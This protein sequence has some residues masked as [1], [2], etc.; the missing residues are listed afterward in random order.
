M[1]NLLSAKSREYKAAEVRTELRRHRDAELVLDAIAPWRAFSAAVVRASK[2]VA[3]AVATAAAA[4]A[5]AAAASS[6]CTGAS[7]VKTPTVRAPT[8]TLLTAAATTATG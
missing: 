1:P 5:A 4:A 7:A 8:L 2:A 3:T 6:I